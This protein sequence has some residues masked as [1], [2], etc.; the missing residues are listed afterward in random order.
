MGAT[1]HAQFL[2]LAMPT[3][4]ADPTDSMVAACPRHVAS[5]LLDVAKLGGAGLGY[6]S[7]QS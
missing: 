1:V 6:Q 4:V 3:V 5:H 7:E 2:A